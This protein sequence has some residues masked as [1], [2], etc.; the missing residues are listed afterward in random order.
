MRNRN[1][2]SMIYANLEKD[3]AAAEEAA[4]ANARSVRPVA[5]SICKGS[6]IS[7]FVGPRFN[8]CTLIPAAQSNR[9]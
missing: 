5:E 9:G 3:S 8:R 6:W 2:I 7:R 4:R 1:V